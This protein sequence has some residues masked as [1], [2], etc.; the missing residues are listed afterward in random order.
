MFPPFLCCV[1]KTLFFPPLAR[2][3]RIEINIR[4]SFCEDAQKCPRVS[5]R[6]QQ[7]LEYIGTKVAVKG[8]NREEGF[9]HPKAKKK[10]MQWCEERH[11]GGALKSKHPHALS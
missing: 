1:N 4:K 3:R 6:G 2:T 11:L 8:Q 10:T 5:M 7:T 9:I